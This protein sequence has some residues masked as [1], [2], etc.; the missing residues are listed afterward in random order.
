MRHKA[1]YFIADRKINNIMRRMDLG[2]D[3]KWFVKLMSVSF[4]TSTEVNKDYFL[5]IIEC[6]KDADDIF[7][8]AI[9][10]HGELF[11]CPTVSY[12]SDGKHEMFISK[13]K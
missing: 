2:H 12:L 4:K 10:Y 1:T 3:G 5:N 11:S 8:P 7:I 9:E 13:E 6:S